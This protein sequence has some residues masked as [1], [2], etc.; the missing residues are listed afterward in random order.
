[1]ASQVPVVPNGFLIAAA[2]LSAVAALLHVGI[3][4][5][6]ADWY[7]FFGAGERMAQLA[8]AGHWYPPLITSL[9]ALVLSSWA[10]YALAGAGVI[11]RL[12]LMKPALCIITAI[13]LLRGLVIIPIAAFA[14][15]MATPFWYWSSAVCLLYG[16]VHLLGL[17]QAWAHL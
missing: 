13:Y 17:R 5:F 6:G 4:V 10:T 14:T 11:R 2:T 3:L 1:M 9:I 8:A 15:S 12:P 7:R 16:L